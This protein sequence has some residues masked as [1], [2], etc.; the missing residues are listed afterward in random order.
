MG[1]NW[2]STTLWKPISQMGQLASY[3]SGQLHKEL[4]SERLWQDG[5]C[6]RRCY[7]YPSTC[8]THPWY[9]HSGGSKDASY[10]KEVSELTGE[11]LLEF[12]F[13]ELVSVSF[14]ARVAIENP[15]QGVHCIFQWSGHSSEQGSC[16]AKTHHWHCTGVKTKASLWEGRDRQTKTEVLTSI[17]NLGFQLIHPVSCVWAR[18]D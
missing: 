14:F 3:S 18:M 1:G 9:S 8:L 6:T 10:W 15:D 13:T 17:E 2:G 5:P 4:L 16:G 11:K 12:S 7:S